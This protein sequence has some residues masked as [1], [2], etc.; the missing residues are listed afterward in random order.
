MTR[1]RRLHAGGVVMRDKRSGGFTLVELMV[2]VVILIVL[3]VVAGGA[4]R[5]YLDRAKEEAYRAEFSSYF[6][7]ANNDT[8]FFP[9]LG[10][11]CSEP[12]AKTWNPAP[13]AWT[14][15]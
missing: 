5:R 10:G 8:T 11:G 14:S 13:A 2:T 12:C 6:S 9:I 1:A 7:T 3:S 4:Y 15:L